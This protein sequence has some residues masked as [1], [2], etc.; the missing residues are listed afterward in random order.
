VSKPKTLDLW[1]LSGF[2]VATPR[3][4]TTKQ[5][6]TGSLHIPVFAGQSPIGFSV[7]DMFTGKVTVISGG[8]SGIGARTAELFVEEA[9][10]VGEA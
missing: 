8:Q 7:I 6:K 10:R 3:D 2:L 4:G 9:A 5:I 1:A